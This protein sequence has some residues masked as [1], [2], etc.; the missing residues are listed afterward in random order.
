MM[1]CRHVCTYPD[2]HDSC[3]CRRQCLS[4]A[5]RTP[6]RRKARAQSLLAANQ[7]RSAEFG[8]A[9]QGWDWGCQRNP[10]SSSIQ[11]C[12]KIGCDGV[13]GSRGRTSGFVLCR[14]HLPGWLV[15]VLGFDHVPCYC[16]WY[17]YL[18]SAAV[19][20][21]GRYRLKGTACDRLKC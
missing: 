3:Q 2:G 11:Q 17:I 4:D 1:I 14:S 9:R 10:S 16:S 6:S 19:V 12:E 18:M 5:S 21:D 8:L 13:H 15:V 7:G 20:E